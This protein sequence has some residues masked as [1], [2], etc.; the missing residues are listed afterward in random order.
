MSISLQ[1]W[2]LARNR[3][4]R[5]TETEEESLFPNGP[6]RHEVGG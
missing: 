6:V 2:V 4:L 1:I 5:G 3:G